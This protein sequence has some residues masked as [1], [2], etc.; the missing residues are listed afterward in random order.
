VEFFSSL[1]IL[2]ALFH[3]RHAFGRDFPYD[4]NGKY[5]Y[6]LLFVM[7]SFQPGTQISKTYSDLMFYKG[8][9]IQFTHAVSCQIYNNKNY[10]GAVDHN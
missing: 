3:V 4:V 9:R 1:S 2:T 10:I 7:T 5:S 6:L 8:T